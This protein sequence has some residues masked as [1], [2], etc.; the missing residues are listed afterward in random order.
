MDI[1]F[2]KHIVISAVNI[3]KGGTL[4]VLKDCLSYLSGRTDL[5]VT[6]LVHD[7]SLCEEPGISYIEIP[8]STRS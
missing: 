8:W 7:R 6:A 3:R 4:T 2:R 1:T 5:H